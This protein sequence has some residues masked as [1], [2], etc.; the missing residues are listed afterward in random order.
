MNYVH[1]PLLSYDSLVGV[2]SPIPIISSCLLFVGKNVFIQ[3]LLQI[4]SI[5]KVIQSAKKEHRV[6]LQCS[7]LKV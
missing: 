2:T 4:H 5:H 1:T 7:E 3:V 6:H